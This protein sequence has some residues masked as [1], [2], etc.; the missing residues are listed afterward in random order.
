MHRH[1]DVTLEAVIFVADALT[2][3]TL[4]HSTDSLHIHDMYVQ[5]AT[6]SFC[7]NMMNYLKG[8]S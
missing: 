6:A 8:T 5:G 3:V 4:S 2:G 7:I 1:T